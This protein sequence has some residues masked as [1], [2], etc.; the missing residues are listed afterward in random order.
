MTVAENWV[1]ARH[2]LISLPAI[3]HLPHEEDPA[4]VT[5]AIVD[6]LTAL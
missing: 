1:A 5:T 3:G 4:A 6:W 2:D